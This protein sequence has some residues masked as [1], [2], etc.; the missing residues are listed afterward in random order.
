MNTEQSTGHCV[1]DASLCQLLTIATHI[2]TLNNSHFWAAI[3]VTHTQCMFRLHGTK[4]CLTKEKERDSH[5]T[6]HQMWTQ[7]QPPSWSTQHTHTHINSN[8]SLAHYISFSCTVH[9]V[10]F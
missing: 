10:D 4:N 8:V 6:E 5:I 3:S 7:Q 1:L 9:M 2:D